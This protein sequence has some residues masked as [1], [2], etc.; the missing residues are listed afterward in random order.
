LA[1]IDAD[2]ECEKRD[3][4]DSTKKIINY[5]NGLFQKLYSANQ[6]LSIDEGMCKF[7]G[8]YS[9]KTYMPLKPIKIGMKFYILTD[10]KTGYVYSFRLYTGNYVPIKNTVY[11]L[12]SGLEGKNHTLYMDNYYNS[13]DLCLV[14]RKMKI[15]ACGTMRANRGEPNNFR[16]KRIGMKEEIFI[17][18][19][20]IT[21]MF[22]CGMTKELFAILAHL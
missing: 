20:R 7:K 3:I 4:E 21:L 2:S 19:R 11:D 5:L 10:S 13:Y 1:S 16:I 9:F 15:F 12:L 17:S 6:E 8:W 22:Y 18:V 14:L